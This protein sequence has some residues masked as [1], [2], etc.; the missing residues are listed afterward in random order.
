MRIK[1]ARHLILNILTWKFL[2]SSL[3]LCSCYTRRNT[4]IQDSHFNNCSTC[5]RRH[6]ECN[7]LSRNANIAENTQ[8][9]YSANSSCGLGVACWRLEPKF[10]GSNPTEAVGFFR[11][12][13][14]PQ[15]AIL[16]KRS[17]AVGPHVVDLRNVK[18]HLNA[19]WKSGIFR[20][21]L[22]AISRPI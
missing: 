9:Y 4:Y 12:Q 16:R 18:D 10:L 19:A 3:Q 15:H 5:I 21:N 17:K 14:Y 2:K 8:A 20:L 6:I 1:A 22:P 11:A 13:K 7:I